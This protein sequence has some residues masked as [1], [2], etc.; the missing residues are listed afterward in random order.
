MINLNY[1]DFLLL[2]DVYSISILLA[3]GFGYSYGIV[4]SLSKSTKPIRK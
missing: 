3:I 1:L 2:L 4:S